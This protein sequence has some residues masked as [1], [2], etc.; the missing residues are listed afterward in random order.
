VSSRVRYEVRDAVARVTLDAPDRLNA[1]DPEMLD[2]VV[3]HVEAAGADP[4]VRVVA[5]TGTGR[6]FSAG[7]DLADDGAPG[8][9]GAS[10]LDDRTLFGVGAVARALVACPRPTVALV[11]GVAAGAGASMALA[12]DYVL[13][14]ESASF[15]LAFARIGLMPDGGATALVAANVGRARAMRMAL[16]GEKVPARL[17]EEW[18]LVSEC[19]ADTDFAARSE[20]LLGRLAGSSP[21]AAAAT[22]AALNAA[23]L[24]LDAA[25]AVEERGQE[26]LLRS[27]DVREGIAAFREKRPPVFRGE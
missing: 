2:A 9:S 4:A 17:A 21:P 8:D 18:G 16:T 23:V 3:G 11:G 6:G 26:G 24:D 5:V 15:V 1:L 19:V 20:E 22:K 14:T 27:A 25:I 13:A 10:E 12:C 7:A